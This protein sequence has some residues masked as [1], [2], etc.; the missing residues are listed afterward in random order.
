MN[1]QANHADENLVNGQKLHDWSALLD[2]LAYAHLAPAFNGK[3][4]TVPEDFIVTEL[5]DVI[6][7]GDGE[8]Y[9][10]DVSKVKCNTEQVAK[11]LARFASV[12]A[13]DV[14]YSGMKDFFA[15]TRQW[16]S[17]WK[18]KGGDPAWHEFK[19]EGVMIHQ[20]VKHSRKIKRGTHRANKFEIV[21]RELANKTQASPCFESLESRL[22]LVKEYGVPNYFGEQRFGRNAENMSQVSELFSGQRNVKSRHLRGL[23]LSSARSWLFNSIVSSRVKQN[24]WQQLYDGEP[25]NLNATNSVFQSSGGPDD[26]QRLKSNDIHPTAPMWGEGESKVM[27]ACY[28]LAQW[29]KD[30][31]EPF[32]FLQKGLENARLDYQRRSLRCIPKAMSWSLSL[33]DKQSPCLKVSFELSKGQF[34]TSVIRELVKVK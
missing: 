24:S 20:V 15:Q 23:L 14:G 28:Q 13:R 34:A 8:H 12:S 29:E 1:T 21:I 10:L 6:P 2:N 27:S 5:M 16:F 19:H 3:L 31:I 11:A 26:L 17:V 32:S 22:S 33:D 18:P 4:K 9:W 7:S 25:A 30:C